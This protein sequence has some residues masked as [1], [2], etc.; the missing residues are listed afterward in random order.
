MP[1]SILSTLSHHV[2][3]SSSPPASSFFM[4]LSH[5]NYSFL[6]YVLPHNILTTQVL[7]NFLSPFISSKEDFTRLPGLD[8][9]NNI[10][11]LLVLK[12]THYDV[13]IRKLLRVAIGPQC[14]I[15]PSSLRLI[16][17]FETLLEWYDND[18]LQ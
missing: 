10:I 18:L 9:K 11:R 8:L 15:S 14:E 17:D 16:S 13:F 3:A 7:R 12:D 6:L 5:C 4:L 2:H 1:W